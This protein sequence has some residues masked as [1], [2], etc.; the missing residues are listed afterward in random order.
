MEDETRVNLL[1]DEKTSKT[2]AQKKPPFFLFRKWVL[3]LVIIVGT[4]ATVLLMTTTTSDGSAF[5]YPIFST[6]S[7]IITSPNKALTGEDTDRINFLLLG[8]GGAGHDGPELTDTIIFMSV[9]PSTR[10]VGMISIPRD[11]NVPLEGYGWRKVNHV[12]AYGEEENGTG[13]QLAAETISDILAQPIDYWVKV[14]FKGFEE[15]IDAIGGVELDVERDFTDPSYPLDDGLGTVETVTFGAGVQEMDGETALKFVRSR[16][17]NNN[18]GSDF[19]R[20]ARQQ[21]VILAVKKKVLSPGTF[22]NP[23][24]I[25]RMIDTLRSNIDTNLSSWEIIR[26]SNLGN[27]FDGDSINNIVLTTAPGS[28]LYETTVNG[29]YVIL[30]RNNDWRPIQYLA[31]HIFE[32][33]VTPATTPAT[34][35]RAA[36]IEI[37]NGTALEGLAFETSELLSVQ[38]FTV[39]RIGNAGNRTENTTVIYDLTNGQ[40]ASELK[41]LQDLLGAEVTLS[42][43]GWIFTNQ[44]VPDQI[45]I[46]DEAPRNAVAGEEIDFLIVLGQDSTHRIR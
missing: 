12:N 37:Q 43:P 17:G 22:L 42:A 27:L 28:P 3:T 20:A 4:F 40:L 2:T 31:E 41:L 45:V 5:G 13:P 10:E 33:G 29:A 36:R 21:K 30:P 34:G 16:H 23:S 26:L 46:S 25:G 1:L 11:L 38:G 9:R 7:R 24:R 39:E 32:P 8:I 6:F 18:E 15:F 44:L 35:T 19:A 14:D